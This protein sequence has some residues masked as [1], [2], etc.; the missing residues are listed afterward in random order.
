MPTGALC[1][2]PV[3]FRQMRVM[4]EIATVVIT[5]SLCCCH[6]ASQNAPLASGN[7][8]SGLWPRPADTSRA[9]GA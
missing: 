3:M 2:D 4:I 8:L 7:A 5:L 1:C 6:A 9:T